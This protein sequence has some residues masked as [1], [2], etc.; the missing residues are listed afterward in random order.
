MKKRA[1]KP[2]KKP[3]TAKNGAA[4]KEL[5]RAAAVP[6]TTDPLRSLLKGTYTNRVCVR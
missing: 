2:T 4:R 6:A 5:P 3:A 1:E